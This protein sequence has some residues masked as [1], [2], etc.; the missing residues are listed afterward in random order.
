M[1]LGNVYFIYWVML[2]MLVK[3]R[4]TH[5]ARYVRNGSLHKIQRANAHQ[6]LDNIPH[7]YTYAVRFYMIYIAEFQEAYTYNITYR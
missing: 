4:S 5:N 1:L 6:T 7:K 2:K 3:F